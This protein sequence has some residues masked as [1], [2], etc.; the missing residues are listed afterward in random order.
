MNLSQFI[1]YTKDTRSIKKINISLLSPITIINLLKTKSN[2]D[3]EY[4]LWGKKYVIYCGHIK[5]YLIE[6]YPNAETSY[7]GH[8]KLGCK[9]MPLFTGLCE[10]RKDKTNRISTT[11]LLQKN[12]YIDDTIGY[13]KM[14]NTT[15]KTLYS[16][17]VYSRGDYRQFL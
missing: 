13:H 3:V 17:H 9:F 4:Q 6:W 8:P 7:H 5:L 15:N 16:I 2:Y 12:Y 14:R 11:E 10:Y 1:Q